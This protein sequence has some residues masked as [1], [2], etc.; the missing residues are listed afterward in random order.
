MNKDKKRQRNLKANF[1][2]HPLITS[3][4]TFFILSKRFFPSP[5]FTE[6]YD[7]RLLTIFVILYVE[8]ENMFH[9]KIR[10]K[11]RR[12][13][14]QS[15]FFYCCMRAIYLCAG[16]VSWSSCKSAW[17]QGERHL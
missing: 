15:F 4:M 10:C 7:K 3:I 1:V 8:K 17:R 9:K 11:G 12:R 5:A 6:S 2:F 14:T 13:I 16:A